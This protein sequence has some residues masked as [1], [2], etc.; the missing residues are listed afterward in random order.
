MKKLILFLIIIFVGCSHRTEP[1]DSISVKIYMTGYGRSGNSLFEMGYVENQTGPRVVNVK[2]HYKTSTTSGSVSTNPDVL[3]K[4]DTGTY[5]FE[6]T[7][8]NLE[9]SV[10]YT[11]N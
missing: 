5:Y 9:T 1:E 8:L 4:G 6:Y 7:G 2:V 10:S 3:D 11:V